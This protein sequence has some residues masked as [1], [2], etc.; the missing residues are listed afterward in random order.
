VEWIKK[1]WGGKIILKGVM[2]AEDAR[3]AA[4]RC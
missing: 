1:L 2:D 3:L 4:K